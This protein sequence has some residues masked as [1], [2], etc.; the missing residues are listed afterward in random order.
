MLGKQRFPVLVQL[1]AVCRGELPTVITRL[2]SKCLWRVW[3]WQRGVIER[4]SPFSCCPVNHEWSWKKT[5]IEKKII[6]CVGII[7]VSV[8]YS[9][10]R[11]FDYWL[12]NGASVIILAIVPYTEFLYPAGIYL[13]KVNI[14]N[15]RIR[16]EICSKLTIKTPK[17]RQW[18]CSGVFIFNFEHISHLVVVFLLLN[19]NI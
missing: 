10:W 9:S 6:S 18:H 5:Q 12:L 4:T 3:K 8:K 1:L 14:R 11:L 17:W 19:Y 15:T 7:T 2:M 13:L 16:C